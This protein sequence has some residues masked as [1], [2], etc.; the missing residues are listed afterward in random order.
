[1]K[2][3]FLILQSHLIALFG[4]VGLDG[5]IYILKLGVSNDFGGV[6]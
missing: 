2:P 4:T 5:T 3:P 6:K 1:M